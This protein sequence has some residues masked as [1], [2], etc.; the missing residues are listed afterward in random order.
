M[1]ILLCGQ[2]YQ[3]V[4]TQ[5]PYS[6][7]F[8]KES[9]LAGSGAALS[10]T[11]TL[12]RRQLKP[13]DLNKLNRDQV[14]SLDRVALDKSSENIALISDMTMGTCA[15]LPFAVSATNDEWETSV[16]MYGESVLLVYGLTMMTKALVH[17]PRPYAYNTESHWNRSSPEASAS[18]FSGHTSLAFNGAVFSS[19]LYQ[20]YN[21]DSGWIKP[22]WAG[23]LTLATVTGVFR[24]LSGKHFPTDVIVGA[25]VGSFT[26]WFVL[27]I[28]ENSSENQS[29][30]SA[31]PPPAITLLAS[32]GT[33][34]GLIKPGLLS[35]PAWSLHFQNGIGVNYRF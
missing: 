32:S 17:R 16:V 12:M 34:L 20:K 29:D 18:F 33:V 6:L 21:P 3:Y 15:V 27:R 11:G 7:R 35:G 2:L 26:G 14:L 30:R 31:V 25:A 28:H 24:V 13:P 4:F 5:T 10:I 1:L 9:L 23:E 8:N 19:L 22:I